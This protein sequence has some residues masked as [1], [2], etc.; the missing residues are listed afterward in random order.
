MRLL[1]DPTAPPERTYQ[2]WNR[3]ALA[4]VVCA[5]LATRLAAQVGPA[6]LAVPAG[7]AL[8]ALLLV[9]FQRTRLSRGTHP[10]DPRAVLAV[11]GVV[12]ALAAASA[13]LVLL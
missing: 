6:A 4:L 11:T 1:W 10:C 12:V 5:L 9:R 13:V 8:A 2:A 7:T 3:T